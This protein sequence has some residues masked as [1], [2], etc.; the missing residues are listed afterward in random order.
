MS[1]YLVGAG[2]GDPGLITV[3]GLEL[4]R[5][6]DALVY[7]RLVA[8]ELVAEAPE[9]ATRI[10]RETL[11]Q[12]EIGEL[13]VRLGRRGLEVVRLKGGDPCLFGRG[14][15]EALALARAGVPCEIVPGVS[16]LTAV[17]AAVGIPVTHRGLSSQVTV[18]SGHDPSALDFPALARAPGTLVVFMGLATLGTLVAGLLANG[19]PARTPA[20]VI[21]SGTTPRQEVVRA[22]L[23]ELAAAAAELEPPALIVVG[24]VVALADALALAA[25]PTSARGR[26]AALR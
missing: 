19:K 8:P 13:L 11:S 2:P 22:P 24:E 20:A 26:E 5:R 10:C 23:G 7:D 25:L 17:P 1:V 16:S 3:R 15:E 18:V 9:G 21:S 12:E 6:C 4:V 14:G